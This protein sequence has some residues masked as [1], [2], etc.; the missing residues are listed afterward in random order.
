MKIK[1]GINGMGRIGSVVS[2]RAKAFNFK[3]LVSQGAFC[4]HHAGINSP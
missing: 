2:L 1:V 4:Y 3:C